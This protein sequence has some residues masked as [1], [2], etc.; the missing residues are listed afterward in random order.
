MTLGSSKSRGQLRATWLLAGMSVVFAASMA[1]AV[2]QEPAKPPKPAT[3]KAAAADPAKAEEEFIRLAE[4][5]IEQACRTCHPIENILRLRRTSQEWSDQI[6]AMAGRGATAT[7]EQ[8]D[9]I[10]QYLTRYYGRVRI[11]SAPADELSA[12][13]GLTAKDAAAV[14]EHRKAHGKFADV[15]AVLKVQGI[16]KTKIEEQPEALVFD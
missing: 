6:T 11:N 7:D 10:Y 16:D 13:L 3:S 14:V 5:T 4:A 1:S 2:G 8:F 9:M 12:V 15:A